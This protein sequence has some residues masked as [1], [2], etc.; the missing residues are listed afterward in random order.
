VSVV[1]L[2][3]KYFEARGCGPSARYRC[4]TEGDRILCEPAER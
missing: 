1:A 3:D 4:V 2:G